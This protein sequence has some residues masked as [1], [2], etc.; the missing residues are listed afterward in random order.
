V[1]RTGWRRTAVLCG[2]AAGLIAL[3]ALRWWYLLVT[4]GDAVSA[5]L[6]AGGLTIFT[7]LLVWLGVLALGVTRARVVSKA[8]REAA[9]MRRR[10]LGA[11]SEELEIQ[12]RA[13]ISLRE[14]MGRAHVF[15][16]RAVDDDETRR[17]FLDHVR[18]GLAA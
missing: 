1:H 7:T 6:E 11:A 8:D 14:L 16:S 4:G 17:R 5:L 9:S 10:A 18:S 13:A 3:G 12:Q 15:S 2:L